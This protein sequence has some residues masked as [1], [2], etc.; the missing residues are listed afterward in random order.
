V[1]TPHTNSWLEL[2]VSKTV[3]PDSSARVATASPSEMNWKAWLR[4]HGEQIIPKLA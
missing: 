2:I 1:L 3:M 4:R